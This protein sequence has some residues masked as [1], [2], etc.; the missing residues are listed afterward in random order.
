MHVS[1]LD[2]ALLADYAAAE[3]GKLTVV[4]GCYTHVRQSQPGVHT[5]YVACRIRTVGDEEITLG[6]SVT[7]PNHLFQIT[8]ESPLAPPEGPTYDGSHKSLIFTAQMSIPLVTN[9]RY[10]VG[11]GINGETVRTLA[12]EVTL[13]QDAPT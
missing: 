2:F 1:D 4:G 5:T 13:Q 7:A 11:I 8:T 12:F 6:L 3:H 9:G 10:E